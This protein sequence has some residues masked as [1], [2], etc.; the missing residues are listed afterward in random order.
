MK[1]S[2]RKVAAWALYKLGALLLT[3]GDRTMLFSERVQGDLSG[4]WL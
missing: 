4:P 1:N 3:A 2:I